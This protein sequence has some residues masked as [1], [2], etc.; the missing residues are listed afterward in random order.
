MTQGRRVGHLCVHGE[1]LHG[2]RIVVEWGGT[3]AI[4]RRGPACARVGADGMLVIVERMDCCGVPVYCAMHVEKGT[5]IVLQ[6]HV[7]PLFASTV[8]GFNLLANDTCLSTVHG[9]SDLQKPERTE[10]H[11]QNI[12]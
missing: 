8:F 10:K 2:L 11:T 1:T 5:R 6:I 4:D 7:F 12:G 3:E 9:S